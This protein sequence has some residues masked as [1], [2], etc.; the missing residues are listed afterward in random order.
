VA[1]DQFVEY[2]RHGGVLSVERS[3]LP[4]IRTSTGCREARS[5]L[6]FDPLLLS[7]IRS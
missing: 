4:G 5:I 1:A 6:P 2:E 3:S 7:H